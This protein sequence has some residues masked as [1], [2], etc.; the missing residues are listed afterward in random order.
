[1]PTSSVSPS[2]SIIHDDTLDPGFGVWPVM[3]TPFDDDLSIDWPTLDLLTDWYIQQGSAGL[4]ACCQS[5][6]TSHM[7]PQEKVRVAEAVIQRAAGRVPVVVGVLGQADDDERIQAIRS[8]HALGAQA[9]IIIPN[10]FGDERT[11]E[12]TVVD[13][14]KTLAAQC[15]E[16][17]LGLYECPVP[18]KRLLSPD[19]VGELAAAGR[20][21]WMKEC[22]ADADQIERKLK[23]SRGTP[24]RIYNANTQLIVR[25]VQLGCWGYTGL[26]AN[27]VPDECVALCNAAHAGPLNSDDAARYDD[28]V[29]LNR[30]RVLV[31]YPRG[32]KAFIRQRGVPIK[33]VCRMNRAAPTYSKK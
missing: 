17:P 15:P 23:A 30:D 2:L 20:F 27:F 24:L 11:A 18:Y 33:P 28:L 9:A 21:I 32:A 3:L 7:T 6:E 16:V 13:R 12:L 31:D 26:A 1:M 19:A 10:A 25:A 5:S 14:M 29:V 8:Y 22:S 4:F